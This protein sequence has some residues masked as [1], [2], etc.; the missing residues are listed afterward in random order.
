MSKIINLATIAAQRK[1]YLLH[2]HNIL[3]EV[4][5]AERQVLSEEKSEMAQRLR[6]LVRLWELAAECSKD[7][8]A[9]RLLDQLRILAAELEQDARE[10]VDMF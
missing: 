4:P 5:D 3:A 1:G 6:G 7:N 9:N 8:T 10:L 2:D